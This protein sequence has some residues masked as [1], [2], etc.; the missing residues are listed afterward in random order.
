MVGV[1]ERAFC[2]AQEAASLCVCMTHVCA[3]GTAYSCDTVSH[4]LFSTHNELNT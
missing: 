1:C 2:A 3:C 4:V